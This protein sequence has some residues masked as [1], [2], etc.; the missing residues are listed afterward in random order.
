MS[1]AIGIACAVGMATATSAAAA[2]PATHISAKATSAY[3]HAG[4]GEDGEHFQ[5]GNGL[6]P[7]LNFC[8]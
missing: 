8:N 4:G 7:I 3:G 6:L 1:T 2:T 5:C